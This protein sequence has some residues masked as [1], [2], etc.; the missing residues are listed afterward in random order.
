MPAIPYGSHQPIGENRGAI[1]DLHAAK[2][3]L[4]IDHADDHCSPGIKGQVLKSPAGV[5]APRGLIDGVRDHAEAAHLLGK[6]HRSLEREQQQGARV[7]AAL[8]ILVNRELPEKRDRHGIGL[9]AMLRPGQKGA[10]DLRGAERNEADNLSVR[11]RGY[12]AGAGNRCRLVRPSMA[13]EPQIEGFLAA[14]E[15]IAIIGLAE[16]AGRR[17]SC[18]V[19]GRAPRSRSPGIS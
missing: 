9:V 1:S 18:H 14:I 15:L 5:K 12:D 13:P 4:K 19:G 8:M 7:P 6:T 2:N 11:Y 10:L 17:Y 16:G 3:V